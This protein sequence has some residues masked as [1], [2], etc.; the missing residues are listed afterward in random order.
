ME[1]TCPFCHLHMEVI[2]VE[3]TLLLL[4][5]PGC[6]YVTVVYLKYPISGSVEEHWLQL[7]QATERLASPRLRPAFLSRES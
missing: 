2:R 1:K 3:P 5:C 7:E 4:R 6:S